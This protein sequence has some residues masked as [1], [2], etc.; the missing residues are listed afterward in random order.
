[1]TSTVSV[2]HAILLSYLKSRT[3]A[4]PPAAPRENQVQGICAKGTAKGQ[5]ETK[6]AVS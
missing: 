1:M 5:R 4:I 3:V 6:V 2:L